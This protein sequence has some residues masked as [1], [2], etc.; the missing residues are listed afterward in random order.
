MEI[1]TMVCIIGLVASM[2]FILSSIIVFAPFFSLLFLIFWFFK[3]RFCLVEM[4]QLE[5]I[6][7]LCSRDCSL[8]IEYYRASFSDFSIVPLSMLLKLHTRSGWIN[9]F[10]MKF[11]LMNKYGMI[12]FFNCWILSHSALNRVAT[13]MEKGKMMKRKK[14]VKKP[15][16]KTHRKEKSNRSS[17]LWNS[18]GLSSFSPSDKTPNQGEQTETKTQNKKKICYTLVWIPLMLVNLNRILVICYA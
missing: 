12:F 8:A 5:I 16:K 1:V 18:R 6:D 10:E 3:C 17:I 15:K 4:L 2:F 13:E 9:K 14:H 7:L 11:F